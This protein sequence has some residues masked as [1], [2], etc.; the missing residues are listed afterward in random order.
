[1]LVLALESST[2]SAKA[3]LYD[4]Q[5]GVVRS[6]SIPYA[7]GI[8][9]NGIS[10]T[11]AVYQSTMAV[12]RRVA[13]G[14]DVA[15]VALGCV[16]HSV[17]ICNGSLNAPDKTYSW[18]YTG[19]KTLCRQ[20]RSNLELTE[21]LYRSTGCMPHS[22]YVRETLR[23]LH[24]NGMDLQ[25]KLFPSQGSYQYYR[26]TGEFL[27]TLNLLCGAGVMNVNR[28]DFD[29]FALEYACARREQFG[30]KAFYT[31]VHPL[32]PEAAQMLGIAPGIPV[33]PAHG[34]GALNQLA[35]C[36]AEVGCMSFSVGTSGA[37]R[38]TTKHPALS[39]GHHL[40][41]YF[42]ITDWISGAATSGA[43][44]CI[45]WFRKNYAPEGMDYAK[46]DS[47]EETYANPPIFLP[48]LFGERNPGWRDDRI[49]GFE[50]LRDECSL[51]EMYRSVQTG[52]LFNLYQCYEALVQEVGK[53][54]KICLSGGILNSKRWTQM[55]SDIFCAPMYCA[56][57]MNA[58]SIGAAILALHAAG[59]I[60][61]VRAYEPD[62]SD[63]Q[64][65]LPRVERRDYYQSLFKQ[66]L[67]YYASTL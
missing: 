67:R 15:A 47:G 10:D 32:K 55:A 16:W 7:P 6:E 3:L 56:K 41:S 11:E 14:Q 13:Q 25:N 8:S 59:A 44:N 54:K 61:D 35:S 30:Q 31:D 27:E 39:K 19:S 5:K 21:K 12:G 28:E 51:Q 1:M 22:S 58:S 62:E 4:S 2:T 57:N 63:A 42:G 36:S 18:N 46:L 23:Y 20:T 66:Y 38:M 45:D 43:C 29:P 48:F 60:G 34:D 49:G 24:A 9:Q 33:V 37:I 52:I 40:W 64:V 65:I 53:P 26:M 50:N 17:A